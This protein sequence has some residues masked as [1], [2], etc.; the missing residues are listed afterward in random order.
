LRPVDRAASPCDAASASLAIAGSDS[1]GFASKSLIDSES[2]SRA[3][4]KLCLL[5]HSTLYIRRQACG[6]VTENL[7][8]SM[9]VNSN[10][11]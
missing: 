5:Y 2:F 6:F 10:R 7:F 9:G 8:A 4:E 11:R 3:G 1:G